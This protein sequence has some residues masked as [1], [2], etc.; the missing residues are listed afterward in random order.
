MAAA[1]ETPGRPAPLQFLNFEKPRTS[2]RADEPA[3]FQMHRATRVSARGR[4]FMPPYGGFFPLFSR[5]FYT[6]VRQVRA[7]VNAITCFSHK[8]DAVAAAAATATGS[9]TVSRAHSASPN[10]ADVDRGVV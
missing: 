10:Y 5:R 1:I 3:R 6:P 2:E 7:V 8:R 4:I 9:H